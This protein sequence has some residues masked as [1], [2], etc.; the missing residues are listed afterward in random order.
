MI[1]EFKLGYVPWKNNFYEE[2]KKDFSEEELSLT[3]LFYKNDKTGKFI[4]RFNSR[5]I[6]Q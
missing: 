2:L 1:K 4:D 6:F 5:I 3:G